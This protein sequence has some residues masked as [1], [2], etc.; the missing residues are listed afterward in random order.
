M[1]HLKEKIGTKKG[2]ILI[3]DV[4]IVPTG[5]GGSLGTLSASSQWNDFTE[6]QV[7]RVGDSLKVE[8]QGLIGEDNPNIIALFHAAKAGDKFIVKKLLSD[9]LSV[10][11]TDKNKSSLL[12]AIAPFQSQNHKDIAQL[13]ISKNININSVDLKKKNSAPHSS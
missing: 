11:T 9:K 12:H 10:H 2:R 7:I 4:G 5:F 8:N 1:K 13:L 3:E 6:G